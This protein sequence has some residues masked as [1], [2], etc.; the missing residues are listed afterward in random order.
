M[1][2]FIIATASAVGWLIAIAQIPAAVIR[3]FQPLIG[4]PLLL[5]LAIN[6]FLLLIGMVI[7]LTPC[8]LIFA[9]VL[10]PVVRAAGIDPHYFGIIMIINLCL[11]LFTPPVGNV[12]LMGCAISG[13]PV[14]KLVRGTLPFLLSVIV[15]LVLFI[16]FP[17][18][19]MVP[20]EFL[21]P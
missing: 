11:S 4:S 18:L 21:S 16:F 17:S 20:M 9:P 1:V 13:L 5:L 2:M 19:V 10:F 7:D 12:L 15:V 3:I 8:I 14:F 6:V